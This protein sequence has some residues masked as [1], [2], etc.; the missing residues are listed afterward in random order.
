MRVGVVVVI[1]GKGCKGKV[2]GGGD[3]RMGRR[4]DCPINLGR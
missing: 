3:L 4:A 1:D 2:R